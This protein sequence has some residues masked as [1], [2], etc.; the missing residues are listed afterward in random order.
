VKKM[1]SAS[2]GEGLTELNADARAVHSPAVFVGVLLAR[3][4]GL[5]AGV[6]LMFL[7]AATLLSVQ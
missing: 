2:I 7:L 1:S 4:F 3:S 6:A 5:A